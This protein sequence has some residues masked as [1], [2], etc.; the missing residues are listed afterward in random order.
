M[1]LCWSDNQGKNPIL[2]AI[3][4]ITSLT[5]N[6]LVSNPGLRS[7]R[8][9]TEHLIRSPSLENQDSSITCKDSPHAAQDSFMADSLQRV[10]QEMVI[11]RMK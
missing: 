7:E 2:S 8:L 10:D 11:V 1:E 3:I 6:G 9:P 4:C 5:W